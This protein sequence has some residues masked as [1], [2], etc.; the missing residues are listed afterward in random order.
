[1]A[2][3]PYTDNLGKDLPYDL[4]QIYAV[5]LVGEH[6]KDIARARKADNYSL[7][8]K[9]LKDLWVIMR[10]KLKNKKITISE[11]NEKKEITKAEYFTNLMNGAAAIAR[12]YPND[13][14]GSNKDPQACAEIEESLNNI[15]MFLYD[16]IEE[17]NMFGSSKRIPGL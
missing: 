1:M 2:D 10:H 11:N 7:Y 5:D 16:E 17:A 8:F 15:E 12:K 4:R 9:C 14:T 6:L 3:K 13:F